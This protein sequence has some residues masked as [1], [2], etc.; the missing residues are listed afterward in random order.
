MRLCSL[1]VAAILVGTPVLAQEQ[2]PAS[3]DGQPSSAVDSGT[4]AKEETTLPVSVDRIREALAAPPPKPLLR[5]I[6][7]RPDFALTVEEKVILEDFFKPEDFKVGPVPPGGLYAHEQQRVLSNSV[8][9]PLHQPYAAFSGGELLTLAIQ[10]LLFKYLGQEVVDRAVAAEK[11]A[12]E[13]AARET[14][15]KAIQ[16]YCAAQPAGGAAV[17]ICHAP[18]PR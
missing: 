3:S 11:A 13:A 10:G 2:P 7:E 9:Q 4:S 5:G 18:V 6:D 16:A 8:D 14:V 15:L 17:E 12:D 1:M